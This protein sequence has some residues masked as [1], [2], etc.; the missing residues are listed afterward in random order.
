MSVPTRL[1]A[2][3]LCLAPGCDAPVPAAPITAPPAVAATPA[4]PAGLSPL[5]MM[6]LLAFAPPPPNP[7][8]LPPPTRYIGLFKQANAVSCPKPEN[9]GWSTGRLFDSNIPA[10]RRFCEYQWTGGPAVQKPAFSNNVTV[11]R[12]DADRDVLIPQSPPLGGSDQRKS[13]SIA[14]NPTINQQLA[15][16]FQ[17]RLSV[18]EAAPGPG[19]NDVYKTEASLRRT[20]WVAIVDT[21]DPVTMGSHAFKASERRQRHGIAMAELVNDVRCPNGL[22]G[23]RQRSLF[24]QAFPHENTKDRAMG[25]LGTLAVGVERAVTS[26]RRYTKDRPA[27]LAPTAP[28]V[29]NLSVGWDADE[30]GD[31]PTNI[32]PARLFS[33]PDPDV[34]APVQAVY[35]ALLHAS[36]LDALVIAASGNNT[37]APCE[38]INP[39]APA[40]WERHRAPSIEQCQDWFSTHMR[41]YKAS[42][43]A[44]EHTPLVYAAGGIV[45]DTLVLPTTRPDSTPVRVLPAMQVVAGS[46]KLRTEAWSGTSVAAAALSGL[47]ANL[48]S[49]DPE[50]S[51]HQLMALIDG[52]SVQLDLPSHVP[53]QGKA[54]R[55]SGHLAFEALRANLPA[56]TAP[57]NPYRAESGTTSFIPGALAQRIETLATIG[58]AG[59][60]VAE[61]SDIRVQCGL[62]KRNL[63]RCRTR[64]GQLPLPPTPKPWLR[65]QPDSPICPDCPIKGGKLVLSLNPNMGV[66]PVNLSLLTL[67]LISTNHTLTITLPDVDVLKDVLVDLG[68]EVTFRHQTY[69]LSA[70]LASKS[71]PYHSGV[72]SYFVRDPFTGQKL[73]MTSNIT[74][75]P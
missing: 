37:G 39:L 74:I 19:I 21:M 68:Y 47:A 73:R 45:T 43:T 49:N 58:P 4:A 35:L 10:L 75:S 53:V 63:T 9:P 52:S 41:R 65:P 2:L 31:I 33:G 15:A 5:G 42:P 27:P 18:V 25:S 26:W 72:L 60:K 69:V 46:D 29:I 11:I 36:C 8:N 3:T 67:D 23:C 55:I 17:G 54:R 57:G 16:A 51:P 12:L 6:S 20:A 66:N 22:P 28:L 56:E 24:A 64:P 7:P 50:L 62:N 61:C 40:R 71:N 48:W 70:L 34:Q 30:Y 38:Q 44:P 14:T 13:P 32:D 1:L 59:N